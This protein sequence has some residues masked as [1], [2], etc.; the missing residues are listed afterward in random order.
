MVLQDV[1]LFSG[2]IKN[3]ITLNDN[4]ESAVIEKAIEISYA[5]DSST[6]YLTE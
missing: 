3:N 6:S 4:I 2:T 5:K 1:F